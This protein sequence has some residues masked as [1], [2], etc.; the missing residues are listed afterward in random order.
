MRIVYEGHTPEVYVPLDDTGTNEV[1]CTRGE[2]V[3]V[4][5]TLAK[6]LL[7][8]SVWSEAEEA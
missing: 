3:E 8:Q 5:D 7:Q 4:P 1:W 6:S 2:P